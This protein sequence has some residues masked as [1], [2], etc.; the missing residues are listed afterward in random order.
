MSENVLVLKSTNQLLGENFFI[1]S[2]Q[3]GYRWKSQQV[4]DLLNDIWDFIINPPKQDYNNEKPFYCLQP[5]VVK[6]YTK[7]QWEVIDGQQRLTT[8]YIILKSLEN[9]LDGDKKNFGGITYETRISTEF[10]LNNIADIKVDADIDSFHIFHSNATVINWFKEKA[11][12]GY[13]DVRTKFLSPFIHDTKVIWYEIRDK[14][15]TK[16]IF[17]R[18][19]IGKI[20]LTNSELIKALYLNNKIEKYMRNEIAEKWDRIEY[21]LKDN[22]FWYFINQNQ[23]DIPNRIEFIFDLISGKFEND[24]NKEEKLH[25]FIFFYNGKSDEN[26]KKIEVYYHSLLEWYETLELYHYVGYLITTGFDN[27]SSLIKIYNDGIEENLPKSTF[28]NQI[29]DKIKYKIKD[30]NIDDLSY[31]KPSDYKKIINILL[32]FNI[33][34]TVSIIPYNYFPFEKY[35]SKQ[36]S[37]EHIHAQQSKAITDPDAIK[38]WIDE[39]YQVIKIFLNDDKKQEEAKKILSELSSLKVANKPDLKDISDKIF[40]FFGEDNRSDLHSI[41]NMALLDRDTNSSLNNSVFPIKRKKILKAEKENGTFIPICTKNVFLKYYSEDISQMYFWNE[42]DRNDYEKE[43][44]VKLK[45]F[46]NTDFR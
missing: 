41:S 2:Y 36:W 10:Q 22:R 30:Y 43:I 44:R 45:D 6:K 34:T 13:P 31:D 20:P 35:K 32:L 18:I 28:L 19:N 24:N 26:W 27:V 15:D 46:L 9:L 33:E 39:T 25:T 23:N 4:L 1:P 37:L 17:E 12:S 14:S 40:N 7:D 5:I 38:V 29:K 11:N 21:S 42:F 8:I 16:S 3:R